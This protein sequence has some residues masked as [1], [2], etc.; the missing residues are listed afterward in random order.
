M[1]TSEDQIAHLDGSARNMPVGIPVPMATIGEFTE[2]FHSYPKKGAA[3]CNI[4]ESLPGRC[5]SPT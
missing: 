1:I 4:I 3:N 2:F 5:L